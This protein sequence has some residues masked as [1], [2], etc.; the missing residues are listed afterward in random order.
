MSNIIPSH[1]N[2][3]GSVFGIVGDVIGTDEGKAY[4]KYLYDSLNVGWDIY[5]VQTQ[6]VEPAPT[7]VPYVPYPVESFSCTALYATGSSKNGNECRLEWETDMPSVLRCIVSWSNAATSSDPVML[8]GDN[9]PVG[10]ITGGYSYDYGGRVFSL[11]GNYWV[12]FSRP[13]SSLDTATFKLT[14]VGGNIRG[15]RLISYTLNTTA[16]LSAENA[17]GSFVYHRRNLLNTLSNGTGGIISP[18]LTGTTASLFITGSAVESI[19]LLEIAGYNNVLYFTPKEMKSSAQTTNLTT[20]FWVD[21]DQYGRAKLSWTNDFDV[22][23]LDV[24]SSG[25]PFSPFIVSASYTF[26]NIA[27]QNSLT[28]LNG[29]NLRFAPSASADP[30]TG[31]FQIDVV[32][33]IN[34]LY[35]FTYKDPYNVTRTATGRSSIANNPVYGTACGTSVVSNVRGVASVSSRRC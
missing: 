15:A 22:K 29:T 8:M 27:K 9:S 33:D 6:S 30:K 32:T 12:G 20:S 2:P 21:H 5:R 19:E 3:S 23:L 31:S 28:V 1:K 10:A 16:S 13:S 17:S 18:T 4:E 14:A 7:P 24:H 25:V 35:E 26:P 11:P 34:G